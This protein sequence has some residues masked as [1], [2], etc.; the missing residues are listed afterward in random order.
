MTAPRMHEESLS[1][2]THGV[3]DPVGSILWGSNVTLLV[4]VQQEGNELPAIYKPTRGERPL[5]DFDRGTLAQREVAAYLTS[6]E[7]GWDMVPPTILREDG[8]A[9]PGSLQLFVD[10]DQ[11]RNYL[12]FSEEEKQRLR[13][14]TLFDLII[15]NAD[16]KAGHVLLGPQDQIWLIDHGVSFHEE[17]KLRTVIWDF[18]GEPVPEDLLQDVTRLRIRMDEDAPLRDSFAALLSEAEIRAFVQRLDA[19]LADP[20][21]PTPGPGRPYPWPLV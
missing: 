2:L 18:V 3:I 4:N 13:P 19:V 17:Y 20:R 12:T 10:A 5:W 11:E 8:P 15:N 14:V 7:L 9:G 6:R 16:R 21:F 1:I